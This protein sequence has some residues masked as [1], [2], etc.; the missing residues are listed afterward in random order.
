MSTDECVE[1]VDNAHPDLKHLQN[2]L[3]IHFYKKEYYD[4]MRPISY[5]PARFL[6]TDRTHKFNKIEDI[7]S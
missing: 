7:N 5:H 3:C 6:V 1:T 4:K 2:L